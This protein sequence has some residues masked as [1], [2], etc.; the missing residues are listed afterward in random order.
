[1]I[2]SFERLIYPKSAGA[3]PNGYMVGIYIPREKLLDAQG[4]TISKVKV[5]G[6][7]LPTAGSLQYEIFGHWAKN[8]HGIQFEMETYREVIE[9]SREGIVAYL[10]SGLIKGIGPAIAEKIYDKFGKDTLD[11]LDTRPEELA[12][13]P[14]ISTAVLER[15]CDSYL[16]SR[17]AR[18]VVAL[19]A[20]HGITANLAVKIF[21]EYGPEST[22][23]LREDPYLL[24]EIAGV[25]FLTAD[26]VA[27]CMG[28]TPASDI[29]IDAGLLYTLRDAETQGHLCMDKTSFIKKCVKLLDTKG[30]DFKFVGGRAFDMLKADRLILYGD[31]VYRPSTAY[32][33]NSVAANVID[34]LSYGTVAYKC[35]LD[36]EISREEKKLG[37]KLVPEQR[38]AI[39]SCLTSRIC[40]VS[41]GPGTGKTLIQRVLLDIFMKQNT[42][43]NVICCAPTGRAARRMEECTDFPSSTI[44]KALGLMAGEDRERFG[45][46]PTSSSD[47]D[48]N[49]SFLDADLVL[50]D[51][52][53]MLDIYLAQH[54]FSSVRRGSQLILVGDADQL[55]SVGPG[56]V[57]SELIAC[58]RIPVVKLDKVFRQDAGS[59]I[60]VNAKLIRHCNLSLE[61]GDDFQFIDSKTY[62]ESAD[63]IERLYRIEAASS[64]IDNVALLTP[65]RTK[66][67]T[68]ANTLN[69]RLRDIINPPGPSKSEEAR[70]TRLFRQGDKV[71]QIKNK[72]D[73][74]NGD[75]GRIT[76]ITANGGDS[77]VRVDF[78]DNRT[79]EYANADLDI[80]DLAYAST[81]HKSQGSEY[82]SVIINIQTGHY[83]MLKRPLIYTAITR[84][85]RRVIIVGDRKALFMAIKTVDTEKRGTML[86]ARI[87]GFFNAISN[88][89]HGRNHHEHETHS[90]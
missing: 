87:N 85:K 79:A 2:C 1:M 4:G 61:Y 20:P 27:A 38:E 84:A 56:A 18:D 81:I 73:V 28:I 8:Q 90:A 25:G 37:L 54:L 43:A 33:E 34:L 83:V 45:E 36:K 52:V 65:F 70:G 58:G 41:G 47:A 17:G 68:G 55:P 50:V 9:H 46:N 89:L 66:T 15:I 53:S 69:S 29:R 11:L 10:S 44:H 72:G 76:D 63:I 86:S 40:I 67:E 26:K 13:I 42:N 59:R 62:E 74:S 21:R 30:A 3:S 5:V 35:N 14:G 75:I 64:G 12:C 39:K 7:Y 88:I 16:E 82:E 80:L 32:A 22:R 57:L 78:G 60:A 31:Q 51:E 6:Y 49:E 19:L 71:M 23:I 48:D 77:G 24:C